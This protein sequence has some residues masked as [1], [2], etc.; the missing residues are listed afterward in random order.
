M[1]FEDL[2]DL[3]LVR[4]QFKENQRADSASCT[5][6]NDTCQVRHVLQHIP[7]MLKEIQNLN[8][9]SFEGNSN[10]TIDFKSRIRF[11]Y[12]MVYGRIVA[13]GKSTKN[14]YKYIL[15][16]STATLEINIFREE[17]ELNNLWKL[18]VELCSLEEHTSFENKA[19]VL[20]SLKNLLMKSREQLSN[21]ELSLGC[22]VL[23]YGKPSINRNCVSIDVNSLIQDCGCIHE[24]MFKDKLIDWYNKN[25][26]L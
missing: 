9:N 18:K 13:K 25:L 14:I 2:L 20:A 19:E 8:Y 6:K 11:R 12:C 10:I 4:K 22:K 21:F 26:L 16:D 24:I 3:F 15:D 17:N 5:W 23:I 1:D 7:L